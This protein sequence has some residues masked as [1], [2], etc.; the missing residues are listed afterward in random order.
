MTTL[1]NTDGYT[2]TINNPSSVFP[3]HVS[4]GDPL[5]PNTAGSSLYD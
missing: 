1:P 2:T 3:V 5:L 4:A